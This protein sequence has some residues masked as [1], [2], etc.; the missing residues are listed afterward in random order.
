HT[1]VIFGNCSFSSAVTSTGNRASITRAQSNAV[2]TWSPKPRPSPSE[3]STSCPSIS[4]A[5]CRPSVASLSYGPYLP[6][7][8][9]LVILPSGVPI[10]ITFL[11]STAGTV[12]SASV[13]PPR[14]QRL[15]SLSKMFQEPPKTLSLSPTCV[16]IAFHSL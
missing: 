9:P 11:L 14:P 3:K 1:N 2:A 16:D 12:H 7:S 6:T 8:G 15:F 13:P 4:T 10:L 5:V